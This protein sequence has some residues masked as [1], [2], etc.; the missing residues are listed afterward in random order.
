MNQTLPHQPIPG[1]HLGDY[2]ACEKYTS[3]QW[4]FDLA[5]G[6]IYNR[7]TGKPVRFR[8]TADG[9][10]I[11]DVRHKGIRTRIRKHRAIWV[12]ANIRHGLPVDA[13]LE[14]DHINHN[15]T[16]CRIRN[17]RLVTHLQ[18][19]RAKPA[20][21]PSETVRQ[22]RTAY[23]EGGV[24]QIQLSR[25]FGISPHAVSRIVRNITYTE[26]TP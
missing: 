26:V 10:L 25:Q 7:R 18:N 17:L 21:L 2:L 1:I 16:D 19:E 23:A 5:A 9:Y 22:I 24:T 12:I 11:T 15:K 13:S 14:I 3:G 8:T 20:A 6:E 4:I